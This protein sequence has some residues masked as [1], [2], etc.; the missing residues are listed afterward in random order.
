MPQHAPRL[1]FDAALPRKRVG[2]VSG[3]DLAAPAV[4]NVFPCRPGGLF[5]HVVPTLLF[6]QPGQQF[7]N[8]RRA[9]RFG[10]VL[11][12]RLPE[13]IHANILQPVNL[14][15]LGQGVLLKRVA[16][17]HRRQRVR[18]FGK[19][20][21]HAFDKPE[22]DGHVGNKRA[23]SAPPAAQNVELK[24]MCQFMHNDM[25]ETAV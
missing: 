3:F 11:P 13:T 8:H 21:R 7:R 19:I 5:N 22:R 2:G 25:I 18:V 16:Q 12:K 15:R 17:P 6:R 14:F 24:G 4:I 23:E 20:F 10:D 1:L 9:M